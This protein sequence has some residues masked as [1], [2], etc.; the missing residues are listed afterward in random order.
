[1]VQPP[2]IVIDAIENVVVLVGDTDLVN[3]PGPVPLSVELSLNVMVQVLVPPTLAIVT[4]RF[5]LL[6]LQ[7]CVFADVNRIVGDVIVTEVE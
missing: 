3:V 7:I 5:V 2:A 6:P 1:M 4:V